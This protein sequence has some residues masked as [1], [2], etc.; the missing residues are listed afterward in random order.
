MKKNHLAYCIGVDGCKD[1]WIA[2]YCPVLNF[3]NAKANHYKTLSHLKNNFAKDSIVI[4][5]MPIGLEV[6]KPNRS[7]DIEARNFLGK[8]SSTIFSP[9]CRDA[10]NSKSYDE[11]K[12][13]NLKKTGKSISKQSWFLSSKILETKNFIETQSVLDIKEGHPEC[14]FAEC[15]GA[16]ILDSKKSLHGIIKRLDIL[17]KL[18]FNPSKLVEELS[19]KTQVKIDDLFDAAIL[20]WT[21]SRY[22]SGDSKTLPESSSTVSDYL[23]H[24]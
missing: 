6:H 20:C 23:I 8:R 19:K 4:I 5:D 10:L 21:A 2:V 1:G 3:S 13:I 17:Q 18:N 24:I 9:P 7:C 15:A 11:A 16:P 12:I 22:A 14:S